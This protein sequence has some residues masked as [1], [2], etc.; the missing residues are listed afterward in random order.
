MEK[1]CPCCCQPLDR[2]RLKNRSTVHCGFIT[3][4]TLIL[5]SSITALGFFAFGFAFL[6]TLFIHRL[7]RNYDA[8]ALYNYLQEVIEN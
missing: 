8:L 6:Q 1:V 5:S 2:G 3:R 7:A 4:P